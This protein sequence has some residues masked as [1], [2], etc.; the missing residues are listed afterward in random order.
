MSQHQKRERCATKTE[1]ARRHGISPLAEAPLVLLIHTPPADPHPASG[2]EEIHGV[3]TEPCDLLLGR[4]TYEIFA[5]YWPDYNAD[6]DS[7]GIAEL[8]RRITKYVVSSSAP[9]RCSLT[10]SRVSDTG[11]VVAHYER[12]GDVKTADAALDTPS[13]NE[14]ARQDRLRREDAVSITSGKPG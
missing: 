7:D 1:K 8:F 2:G 3:L 4:K 6:V 9:H 10:R 11:L 12:A 5:A 14:R 13:D